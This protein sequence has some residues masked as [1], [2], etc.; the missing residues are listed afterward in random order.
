MSLCSRSA[1]V[2]ALLLAAALPQVGNAQELYR[3]DPVNTCGGP[4]A[5][6]ARNPGGLGWFSEVVDNFDAPGPWT[7][8]SIEFW[9]GY[10][11]DALG[12]TEGF[13]VRFYDGTDGLIGALI[14]TQDIVDFTETEYF[15]FPGPPPL[16]GYHYTLDL[17]APVTVPA[18]SY[19]MSVTAILGRGG[20]VNEPQ[21]GWANSSGF[22][23]P[24]AQQWFFAPGQFAPIGSDMSFVLHAADSGPSCDSDFNCDGNADQDDIGCMINVVAGNPGC[25]C[26]DPDFNSDGNVDQDD[27]AALINVVAGGDCP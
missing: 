24:S 2:S 18:G 17:T 3:Q 16:R 4:S 26:Q 5:Q 19:W 23:A 6:D 12:N 7:I 11:Q 8:G 22:V 10:C 1:I 14:S 27:V 9:G 21:W 13:M 20:S 25:E 15:A